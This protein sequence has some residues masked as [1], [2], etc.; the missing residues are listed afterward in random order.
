MGWGDWFFFP[1]SQCVPMGL[2]KLFPQ[3]V[4]NSTSKLFYSV[5][6][7]S[8]SDVHKLRRRIIGEHICFYFVTRIQKGASIRVRPMFPKTL[9]MCQSM[10]LLQKAKR[11]MLLHPWTLGGTLGPSRKALNPNPIFFKKD[12]RPM[13]WL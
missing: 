2:P 7:K 13:G 4:P 1:C 6:P 8:N 5:C 11:K 10:W 9:V 3:D 12:L